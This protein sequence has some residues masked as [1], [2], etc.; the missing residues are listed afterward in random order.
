M[1]KKLGVGIIGLGHNG[2]AHLKDYQANPFAEVKAVCDF[3]EEKVERIKE[4]YGIKYGYTNYQMLE[5]EDI[6][7]ISINTPDHLHAEPFI[8][9]L[10]AG[11]H[12]FVEKPMAD[13]ISDLRKMM[14]AAEK[15]P[16]LKTMVGQILRFNPLFIEIK[17]IIEKGTLGKI[18]YLEGDYI[19]NLKSQ[20]DKEKY[21]REI[22]MNWYLERELP[23]VGGGC[24]P[25]DLLRWFVQDELGEVQAYGNRLTFSEMKND[26]SVVAIFKFRG[27]C[28]GKVTALY[29]PIAPYAYANN[30]GVYG[31]KGTILR[32]TICLEEKEGFTKIKVNYSPSHPYEPEVNHFIDCILK[33][34]KTLVEAR[35]GA[36]SAAAVITVSKALKEKRP[37]PIPEF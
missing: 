20:A 29:E 21:N 17:R 19:H 33:D 16:H 32:D 3:S 34:K 36:R 14:L 15:N 37:I 31:T 30:I 35:D 25:L 26:S 9:S 8:C 7:V 1:E 5:R 11:K 28:L 6:Q 24:H 27:G 22:K 23:M 4:K 13:N 12:T 18:F 2:E 10:E